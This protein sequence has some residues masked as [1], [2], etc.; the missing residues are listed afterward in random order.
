M[1]TCSFASNM[2]AQQSFIN[3]VLISLHFWSLTANFRSIY[4]VRILVFQAHDSEATSSVR[5]DKYLRNSTTMRMCRD[6]IAKT[7]PTLSLTTT[8]KTVWTCTCA[9]NGLKNYYG[10]SALQMLP[11]LPKPAHVPSL[12][13][14]TN[15]SVLNEKCFWNSQSLRRKENRE[16]TASVL[17]DKCF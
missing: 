17:H 14:E 1:N 12:H 16:T 3:P 2:C 4:S 15:T 8:S 9:E 11:K 13:C 7:Q 5:S 6:R 10:G